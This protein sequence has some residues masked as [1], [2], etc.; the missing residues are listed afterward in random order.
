MSLRTSLGCA[1]GAL[2]IATAQA[3]AAGR[4]ADVITFA[5]VQK[6]SDDSVVPGSMSTLTRTFDKVGVTIDTRMLAEKAPYTIWWIIFNNPKMCMDRC[7][8]G[9]VDLGNPEVDAGVFWATGRVSDEFGQ[10]SFSA[11]TEEFALPEGEDQVRPLDAPLIESKRAEIHFVVR[12]HGPA[13]EGENLEAQLTQFNGGCTE[14]LN[15]ED[16]CE[17]VQFVAHPAPNCTP[18]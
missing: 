15:G 10:A 12:A 13:L 5:P 6:L 4:S 11:F 16:A 2:L 17:D 8:C 7:A 9:A 3:G 14:E 1:L 18:R